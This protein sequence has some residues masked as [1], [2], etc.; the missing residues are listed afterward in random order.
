MKTGICGTPGYM[1]P[2]MLLLGEG[3]QSKSDIWS[4]GATFFQILFNKILD[5]P[6]K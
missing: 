4:L 3:F 6:E 1:D 5:L 2:V